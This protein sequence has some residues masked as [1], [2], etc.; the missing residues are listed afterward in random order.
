MTLQEYHDPVAISARK[1]ERNH[2]R[3]LKNKDRISAQNRRWEKKN[4]ERCR[5][6]R[7]RFYLRHREAILK[8]AR[9]ARQN[10][11]EA[12]RL[13]CRKYAKSSKGIAQRKNYKKT[14]LCQIGNRLRN[15][16]RSALRER[17]GRKAFK[18]Q[19]LIGCSIDFLRQHLES[20]FRPGMSWAIPGSFHIDHVK[21]I[22]EFDLTDPKQQKACFSYTN[23]Q[24]LWA[25]E[26]LKKGERLWKDY[27]PAG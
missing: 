15:R 22:K 5:A 25:T 20:K 21:P 6:K 9:Q 18:T 17:D 3:Y 14:L 27:S 1:R 10:S 23:L 11:P 8:K 12:S 7:K 16:I 4:P 13:A 26:N 24:P 19:E 2:L